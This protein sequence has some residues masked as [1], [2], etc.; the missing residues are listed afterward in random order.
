MSFKSLEH[1]PI[2]LT[3]TE[4]RNILISN[5]PWHSYV[6]ITVDEGLGISFIPKFSKMKYEIMNVLYLSWGNLYWR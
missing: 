4:F 1:K 3:I 6:T 5:K 2:D